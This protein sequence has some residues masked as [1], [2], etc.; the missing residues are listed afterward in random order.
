MSEAG[1]PDDGRIVDTNPEQL[2]QI[3]NEGN[4]KDKGPPSAKL[5]AVTR[6]QYEIVEL[7]GD[8]PNNIVEIRSLFH[9]YLEKVENLTSQRDRTSIMVRIPY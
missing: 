7:L 3:S 8:I 2:F 1:V 6:K 5:A 9:Q 4:F